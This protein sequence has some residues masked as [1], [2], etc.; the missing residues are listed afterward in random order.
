MYVV[1]CIWGLPKDMISKQ[2]SPNIYKKYTTQ[3]KKQ[4]MLNSHQSGMKHTKYTQGSKLPTSM[5]S[6]NKTK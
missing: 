3:I 4:E 5:Q 6:Q 2:K 1:G